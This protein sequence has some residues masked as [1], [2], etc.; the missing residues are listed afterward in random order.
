MC[1]CVGVWILYG[2]CIVDCIVELLVA[3]PKL[4]L[5]YHHQ[6]FIIA[7]HII[8]YSCLII[9]SYTAQ[10]SHTHTHTHTPTTHPQPTHTHS[11]A[12]RSRSASIALA[13]VLHKKRTPLQ[14]ALQHLRETRPTAQPNEHF[15]EQ[16]RKLQETLKIHS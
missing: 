16:L 14:T 3:C 7:V 15:M 5:L 2:L 9:S 1:V 8:I 6:E 13:Y 12:G 10:P 4:L 11:N